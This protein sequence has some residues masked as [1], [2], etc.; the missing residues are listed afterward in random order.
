M[1]ALILVTIATLAVSAMCSLFEAALYSTRIPALEA[2]SKGPR[3]AT[4][5]KMLALKRNVSAPI[6]AILILNTIANSAGCTLAGILAAKVLGATGVTIYMTLLVIGILF[7][8]EIIPKTIGAVH[9]R[10]LWPMIV[11]PLVTIQTLLSVVIVAIQKVSNLITRG[12]HSTALTEEEILAVVSLGTQ[13]GHLSEEEGEM[14]RNIIDL[15][16]KH[17]KDVMTPRVVMCTL[18]EETTLEE[19]RILVRDVGFSRIP[20]Y[21][22]HPENIT[23]YILCRELEG[24]DPEMGGQ[25][26]RTKANSVAFVPEH[27]N[28]LSLLNQFLKHRRHIAMVADEYGGLAGMITLEDLLETLLGSEIVDETDRD[29]DMRSVARRRR[30]RGPARHALNGKFQ[31]A[32]DLKEEKDAKDEK[33]AE[34][35]VTAKAAEATEAAKAA[36]AVEAVKVA[37]AAKTA[38]TEKP[39]DG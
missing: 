21:R 25:T 16:N 10:T 39:G 13:E 23:G 24:T 19:A 11:W 31:P 20:V 9:W 26:L 38:E 12:H 7:L 33:D 18:D 37:K 4:A 30:R 35:A 34:D 27:A 3:A 14:V 29:I 17:A 8:S 1:T 22:E 36:K 15:E 28:C 2:A 5:K 32:T 6:S